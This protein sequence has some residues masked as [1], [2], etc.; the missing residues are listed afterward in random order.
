[1]VQVALIHGFAN[2]LPEGLLGLSVVL[3]F[4]AIMSSIDT[5]IFTAGASLIQDF[6][7]WDKRRVVRALRKVIFV[8]AILATLIS[9]WIQDLIIGSYIFVSFVVVIAIAVLA[10]WIRPSV[11]EKTLVTE[12]IF[13][14]IGMIAFVIYGL[15]SGGITP[16]LVIGVLGSSLLGLLIGGIISRLTK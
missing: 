11:K 16:S 8:L 4:A 6:F 3:L 10:T 1:M 12:F 9:I 2:L 14:M 5:Y 13:G 15:S 7:D